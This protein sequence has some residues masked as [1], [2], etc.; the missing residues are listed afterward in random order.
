MTHKRNNDKK[1]NKRARE[2]RE[3]KGELCKHRIAL[4]FLKF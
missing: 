4:K 2:E 1:K 3:R